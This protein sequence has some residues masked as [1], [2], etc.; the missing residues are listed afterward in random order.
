MMCIKHLVRFIHNPK[1][2]QYLSGTSVSCQHGAFSHFF[3]LF[4]TFGLMHQNVVTLG[5]GFL[6]MLFEICEKTL[7]Q[8]CLGWGGIFLSTE[9]ELFGVSGFSGLMLLRSRVQ[10]TN[11]QVFPWVLRHILELEQSERR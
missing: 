1:H 10:D 8:K 6:C 4:S 3:R 9:A 2:M 11:S 5:G 7:F